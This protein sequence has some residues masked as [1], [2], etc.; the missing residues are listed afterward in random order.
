MKTSLTSALL[1]SFLGIAAICAVAARIGDSKNDEADP[2]AARAM[3][4]SWARSDRQASPLP[5]PEKPKLELQSF[6]WVRGGFDTSMI[7]TFKIHNG[8][9]FAVKDIEVTCYHA[10]KSGTIIDKNVR[11]VYEVIQ[12]GETKEIRDF[13][14]GFIDPQA[15]AS[16]PE[17][18]NAV[19]LGL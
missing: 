19:V 17:I 8:E 16:K 9:S 11:T 1:I 14:M 13:N 10:A 18:T 2:V 15:A 3:A 4:E 6:K 7:A 5:I 12:P